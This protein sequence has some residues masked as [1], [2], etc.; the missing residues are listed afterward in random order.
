M[1]IVSIATNIYI[2]YWAHLAKSLDKFLEDPESMQLHVFTDNIERAKEIALE[3]E[4]ISVEVWEIPPLRWPEATLHRYRII[5]H[6]APKLTQDFIMYLDADMV[7]ESP[8]TIRSLAGLANQSMCFVA[9]PGFYRPSGWARAALYISRPQL[10]KDDFLKVV[11][12]G[13]LGAWESSVKSQAY[14]PKISRK[15][16]VCGGTWFGTREAVLG[17]CQLLDSR[18]AIDEESRVQAVW[19]DESH[20]NWFYAN[21][22]ANIVDPR[23]CMNPEY[24]WLRGLPTV[25]R[26]VDK[27]E[28]T[29]N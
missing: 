6:Y 17:M 12:Q 18:V 11:A 1:A 29:R 21:F 24:P 19:H 27:T 4:N 10:L 20:L 16:Y 22:P 9:H 8:F 23:Y 5:A 25:I 3:L 26:A 7:I 14:V 15:H 2:E 13:G 28:R